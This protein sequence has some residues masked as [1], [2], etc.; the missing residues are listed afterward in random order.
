M[1]ANTTPIFVIRGATSSTV[2]INASNTASDGSGTLYTLITA[3]T[4]GT[5]VD[6]V[7]FRNASTGVTASS[8]MLHRIFLTDNAG[9]NP[10][11]IGEVATATATRNNTT[12]VGATSIF[13][14][15]QP[16]IMTTGQLLRVAQS[17]YAGIQDQVDAFAYA[18]DF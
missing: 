6:S 18:G 8:N 14:F 17:A 16:L 3:G 9:T 12:V 13:T 4:D 2:R 15:D 5:R 7:R 10:R 11:L 1:P